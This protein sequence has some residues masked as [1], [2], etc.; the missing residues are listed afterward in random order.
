MSHELLP[1]VLVAVVVIK[2]FERIT[3]LSEPPL[4]AWFPPEPMLPPILT[5]PEFMKKPLPAPVTIKL[6]KLAPPVAPTINPPALVTVPP[7]MTRE[8]LLPPVP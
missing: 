4:V 3:V 8:L 7:L 6:L 5:P 2:L 1:I